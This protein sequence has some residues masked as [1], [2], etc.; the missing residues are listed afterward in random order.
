M[1]CSSQTRNGQRCKAAALSG[2][3]YCFLHSAPEKA[4][5]VGARG[6]SRRKVF[7][8]SK[9]KDFPTAKNATDLMEVTAQT[10]SDVRK[11]KIDAKVA[12]AIGGLAGVLMKLFE[13]TTFEE[14]LTR[15]EAFREEYVRGKRTH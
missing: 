7:D 13:H 2:Q 9:L 1:R 4:R 15:L 5:E 10:L 3:P 12:N 8:L 14:R 11:G 6:G